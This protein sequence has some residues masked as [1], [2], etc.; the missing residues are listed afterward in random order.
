MNATATLTQTVPQTNDQLPQLVLQLLHLRG[1]FTSLV[2]LREMKVR[3]GA[4]AVQKESA[5]TCRVGVNYD[6][7]KDVIEKREA[8]ILP[9][10]NAGLPWGQWVEGCFPHLIEHKGGYYFRCTPVDGAIPKSRFFRDGKEITKQ[11]AQATCLASE[12]RDHEDNNAFTVKV[13]SIRQINGQ[14]VTG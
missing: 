4:A 2:T 8:D 3:K 5:F 9:K 6:N 12:F 1:Q 10:E 11:E 7:Q 14:E 13:S